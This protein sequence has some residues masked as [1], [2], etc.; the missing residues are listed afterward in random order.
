MLLAV[1][2]HYVAERAPARPRAIFPVTIEC[3]RAQVELLARSFELVSR[4]ELLAAVDGESALPERACVLTFDDGLRCHAEL[5]LPVLEQL[6]APAIFFVPGRPLAE[7]RMLSVHK[8]HALRERLDE[9][10]FA[11]RLDE[12][13]AHRGI[14]A[15]QVSDAEAAAR[16]RYDSAEAAR[17]KFLLNAALRPRERGPIVD[18]LFEREFPDE[19]VFAAE[20]YLDG[21]QVAEL[22]HSHHS[23]GAHSYEHEALALLAPRDLARDVRRVSG[24]LAD[25]TGAAPRAFSY[26]YGTAAAVS[27]AT[28]QGLQRAGYSAAFTM[29]RAL[30]RTL[31][32]PLLLARLD[33]NDA[34]GGKRPLLDVNGGARVLGPGITLARERY[35]HEVEMLT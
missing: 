7:G 6:G 25:L 23:V 17:V 3:L 33:T 15:P 22:E 19:R 11:E 2:Y 26:P 13:L 9:R 29:E 16:Y 14:E 24:V 28:A 20:L 12:L 4:D 8:V 18:A 10:E 27:A 5:A 35:F 34:P 30:N 31:D 21:A 1:A 32:E